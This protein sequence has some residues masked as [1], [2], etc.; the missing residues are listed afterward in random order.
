MKGQVVSRI[1]KERS[2]EIAKLRFSIAAQINRG[3]VGH[4]MSVVATE[5]GKNSST[6]CRDECYVPVVLR[7]RLEL[8][9]RY[10]TEIVDST[11]THLLGRLV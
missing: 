4:R 7:E 2:R 6:V 5:I 1:S 8:A 11:P 3:R 9:M 10:E